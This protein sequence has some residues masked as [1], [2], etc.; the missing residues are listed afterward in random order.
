MTQ[1]VKN[2]ISTKLNY[3]VSGLVDQGIDLMK[4]IIATNDDTNTGTLIAAKAI[5][6]AAD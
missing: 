1:V 3:D 4:D 5:T 6:G 2:K